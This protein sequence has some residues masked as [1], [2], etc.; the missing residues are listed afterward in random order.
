MKYNFV[1]VGAGLSGSV[2]ASELA[3]DKNKSVLVV[4]KRKHI[5]GNCFDFHSEN[6]ILV[7]QYGPHIFHTNNEKV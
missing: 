3:K 7:H 2:L 5:A 1:I 4:E 6:G